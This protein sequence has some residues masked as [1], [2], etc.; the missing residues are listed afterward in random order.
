MCRNPKEIQKLLTDAGADPGCLDNRQRSTKYYMDHKQELELP[1]PNKTY[2]SSRKSTAAKDGKLIETDPFELHLLVHNQKLGRN[3]IHRLLK[4]TI[5]INKNN[6][7]I[8]AVI[9]IMIYLY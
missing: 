4:I 2:T 6:N 9:L 3:Y 7:N 5:F 1:N 8:Y